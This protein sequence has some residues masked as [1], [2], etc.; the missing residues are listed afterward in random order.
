MPKGLKGFQKGHKFYKGGEKGWFKT[1]HKDTRSPEVIARIV[2]L[3]KQRNGEKNPQWKGDKVSYR[4]LHKWIRKN[5]P[6]Q[7]FCS[8]CKQEKK[9][10]DI[11]NISGFY[12]REI[13]D[14]EWLCRMCHMN[15]DGR[16]NKFVEA[17][18]RRIKVA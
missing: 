10:L 9:K 18:Q 2:F 3:A 16:W 14:F 11:A 5:K 17:R 4:E 1:G 6:L 7:A 12:K 15:K 8:N 13:N